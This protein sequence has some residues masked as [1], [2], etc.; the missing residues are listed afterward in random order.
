MHYIMIKI[1]Q[2][3]FILLNIIKL[4]D[5]CKKIIFY[6]NSI[7]ISSYSPQTIKKLNS[8]KRILTLSCISNKQKLSE[9]REYKN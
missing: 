7:P 2:K 3:L 1:K 4:P 6:L 5:F 8:T 9:Q